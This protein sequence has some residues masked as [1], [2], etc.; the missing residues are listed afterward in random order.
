N[1]A[2]GNRN[3]TCLPEDRLPGV[4]ATLRA[5][6][7][8][9]A[10]LETRLKEL[11]T[12]TS[13]QQALLDEARRHLWRLRESLETSDLEGQRAVGREVVSKVEVR[14]EHFQTDGKRSRKGKGG[15]LISRATCAV[16]YVR[17]QIGLSCLCDLSGRAAARWADTDRSRR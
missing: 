9:K 10:G 15:K 6:E 2:Q 14:F 13:Q 4:V 12:G 8:E 17:D 11:E 3:L 1:I 16:V 5:L 7:G